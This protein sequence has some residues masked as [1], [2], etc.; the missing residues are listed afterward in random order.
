[1]DDQ[2]LDHLFQDQLTE[3]TDPGSADAGWAGMQSR[4]V[5]SPVPKV[6]ALQQWLYAAAAAV[7]VLVGVNIWLWTEIGDQ[8]SL[9]GSG[10]TDQISAGG[11][12]LDSIQAPDQAATRN[13]E[14]YSAQTPNQ[15]PTRSAEL[16]SAQIPNQGSTRSVELNS[17]QGSESAAQASTHISESHSVPI[18][19]AETDIPERSQQNPLAQPPTNEVPPITDLTTAWERE[20]P[21]HQ[22]FN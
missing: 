21:A 10:G 9:Q 14:L 13:P 18:A 5:A 19:L 15:V 12:D 16:N 4:M 1:M 3:Y 2:Q 7:A 6:V 22:I 20:V 8:G 11:V 17:A